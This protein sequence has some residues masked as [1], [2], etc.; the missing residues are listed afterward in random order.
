MFYELQLRLDLSVYMPFWNNNVWADQERSKRFVLFLDVSKS[1]SGFV[2]DGWMMTSFHNSPVSQ[3]S[4][5]TPQ[6]CM[7]LKLKKNG[8]GQQIGEI[9]ILALFDAR[10]GGSKSNWQPA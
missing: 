10:D 6:F 7:C 5:F 2:R 3:M 1:C 9:L 4:P 8:I